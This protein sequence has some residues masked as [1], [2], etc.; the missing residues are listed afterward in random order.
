MAKVSAGKR[1]YIFAFSTSLFSATLMIGCASNDASAN[2][3][4]NMRYGK[5]KNNSYAGSATG[6]SNNK[7]INCEY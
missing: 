7:K 6:S 1:R 4:Q 2:K 3:F 5:W